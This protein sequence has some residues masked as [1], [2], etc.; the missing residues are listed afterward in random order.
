MADRGAQVAILDATHGVVEDFEHLPE[1]EEGAFP[2]VFAQE[3]ADPAFLTDGTFTHPPETEV[4]WTDQFIK[5]DGLGWYMDEPVTG[6]VALQGQSVGKATVTGGTTMDLGLAGGSAGIATVSPAPALSKAVSLAGQSNGVASTT[7]TLRN[8]KQ[9][10]GSAAGVATVTATGP[11]NLG[12]YRTAVLSDAPY[13]FAHLDEATGTTAYND[14]T[15]GGGAVATYAGNYSHFPSIGLVETATT[16]SM[17]ATSNFSYA[18]IGGIG[19]AI[20]APTLDLAVEFWIQTTSTRDVATFRCYNDGP[21]GAEPL[22]NGELKASGVL[23][24]NH[25]YSYVP[26][27]FVEV[28]STRA[29]NDGLPHHI[30]V[31]HEGGADSR[32]IISLYIDGQLNV[33]GTA[34]QARDSDTLGPWL[35]PSG[36][37]N[38]A[39]TMYAQNPAFVDEWAMYDFALDGAQVAEHYAA[40]WFEPR[41]IGTASGRASVS[42]DLDLAMGLSGASAGRAS[43]GDPPSQIIFDSLAL[44][45]GATYSA[46]PTFEVRPDTVAGTTYVLRQAN[47]T[48]SQTT[49]T[50]IPYVQPEAGDL[51]V[52]YFISSEGGFD[53]M[54]LF[55]DGVQ[56]T[57]DSGVPGIYRVATV[58]TTAGP[59][60]LRIQYTK[61]STADSGIDNVDVSQIVFGLARGPDLDIASTGVVVLAGTSHG[62]A[63]MAGALDVLVPAISGRIGTAPVRRA[64]T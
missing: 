10:A 45:A 46:A 5:H 58:A 6:L 2:E 29:I 59:H 56:F 25:G 63:T 8:T 61:D 54:R 55:L 19:T 12:A 13:L 23:T 3:V 18:E 27:G 14:S 16:G 37:Q 43:I 9:L 34:A 28:V 39:P 30:V 36:G 52:R 35:D 21:L 47:I 7:P 64:F 41:L 57:A 42:G 32:P 20:P 22:L 38:G 15:L 40:A 31:V 53:F 62:L 50:D 26:H 1:S 11:R 17:R 49:Y 33:S 24:F 51:S 48:H 44:P 60:T 4:D